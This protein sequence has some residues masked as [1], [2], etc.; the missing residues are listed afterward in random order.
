MNSSD[1]DSF[2]TKLHERRRLWLQSN[3]VALET[4]VIPMFFRLQWSVGAIQPFMAEFFIRARPSAWRRG[5]ANDFGAAVLGRPYIANDYEQQ[6]PRRHC[7]S[8]TYLSIHRT[9]RPINPM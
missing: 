9:M 1:K 2:E 8:V 4:L 3:G 7:R 5:A 6:K